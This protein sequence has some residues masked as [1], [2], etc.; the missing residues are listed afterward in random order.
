MSGTN[1]YILN[2]DLST[3]HKLY[4]LANYCLDNCEDF[5]DFNREAERMQVVTLCSD[6]DNIDIIQNADGSQ[7][8]INDDTMYIIKPYIHKIAERF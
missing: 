4:N 6:C 2:E 7:I 5:E 8:I 3:I 1:L